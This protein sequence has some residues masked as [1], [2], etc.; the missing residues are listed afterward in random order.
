MSDFDAREPHVTSTHAHVASRIRL[1]RTLLG[2]S[3]DRLA[4]ALGT[5]VQQVQDYERGMNRIGMSR[6]IGLAQVFGVP[7]GFFHDDMP[8]AE[9]AF[10]AAPEQGERSGVAEALHGFG[11]DTSNQR[12]TRELLRAYNR[13][14]EPA[15]RRQALEMVRALAPT[16]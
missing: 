12:E 9:G 2:M 8:R 4:E 5:T 16:E 14:A 15:R 11:D 6:L 13:I 10:P 3:Q 7:V 1:R